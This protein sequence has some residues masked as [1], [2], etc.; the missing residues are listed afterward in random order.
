MKDLQNGF[1]P[2][3]ILVIVTAALVVGG[4]AY[5]AV[6]NTEKPYIDLQNSER[7]ASQ[8]NST[9]N[10]Q[11]GWETYRNDKYGFEFQYPTNGYVIDD[12]STTESAGFKTVVSVYTSPVP[13][14][15][16]AN[17][18]V[19]VKDV[20][21]KPVDLED[22]AR[23]L[24][25]N[26]FI[27]AKWVL[28]QLTDWLK[29]RTRDDYF[30]KEVSVNY[31]AL[32]GNKIYRVYYF[33]IGSPSESDFAKLFSSFKLTAPSDTPPTSSS[34]KLHSRIQAND[35]GIPLLYYS[36]TGSG[37]IPGSRFSF[38][39]I[40]ITCPSG[41]IASD[42]GG[43][44]VCGKKQRIQGG[45]DFGVLVKNTTAQTQ[46]LSAV[47]ELLSEKDGSPIAADR[48]D[49]SVSPILAE[50][51]SIQISSP[52]P[53]TKWRI[54]ST[55]SLQWTVVPK[56]SPDQ[57][58]YISL[59]GGSE[60]ISYEYTIAS[61]IQNSGSFTWLVGQY[62]YNSVNKN[63]GVLL[64]GAYQLKIEI[65]GVR[66]LVYPIILEQAT[67]QSPFKLLFNDNV[68][69]APN[70]GSLTIPIADSGGKGGGV[71][72]EVVLP[73]TI[74]KAFYNTQQDIYDF[75]VIFAPTFPNPGFEGNSPVKNNVSG[76]GRMVEDNSS[77]YGSKGTLKSVVIMYNLD[78]NLSQLA[79]EISHQWLMYVKNDSLKINRDSSHWSQFM[80]TATRESG[81]MYFS[82]NGGNPFIDNSNGTFSLDST[83]PLPVTSYHKFNSLELYLM[84]LL[85]ESQVTPLAL[86]QT[87]S[88]QVMATMTGTKK[89][90]TVEDII[91]IA[92]QRNPAYPNT[93]KDFKIA[94][95]VLPQKGQTIDNVVLEKV[96]MIVSNF[97][98]E[99]NFMTKKL[100]N[101]R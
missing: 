58:V 79:H 74:S 10:Q 32:R 44:D 15:F 96:K 95:I 72:S 14:E 37:V 88:S 39:N 97:P 34:F 85:P 86:W 45:K 46:T 36:A 30:E 90:V 25:G 24:F 9:S 23:N 91:N 100:S 27:E 12:K 2:M 55:Q 99:W 13:I 98:T 38:W 51:F 41:V 63:G 89:I 65:N 94:Y 22:F 1:A 28:I 40:Q 50:D 11:G 48:I 26:S 93:Q 5:V 20:V 70:D 31:F 68:F 59:I 84:G 64:P 17:F 47:S 42:L 66:Q 73:A 57:K 80:D 52:I 33:P 43:V 49:T 3:V 7:V 81:Y 19:G 69:L 35:S 92:G 8:T 62:I 60:N 67:T 6:K 61:G 4:G 53:N 75:M 87:D 29:V 82:P 71:A 77:L 101:I 56:A 21:T 54:G 16:G 18:A 78:S 83:T 76:I